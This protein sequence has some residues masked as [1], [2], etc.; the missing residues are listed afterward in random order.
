MGRKRSDC[1]S[2]QDRLA[3]HRTDVSSAPEVRWDASDRIVSR[4]TIFSAGKIF[5]VW[6]EQQSNRLNKLTRNLAFSDALR[7]PLAI[8]TNQCGGVE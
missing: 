2:Q 6:V 7:F 1:E 8:V 5:G 4:P 3:A